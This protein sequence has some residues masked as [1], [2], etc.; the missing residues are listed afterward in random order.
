MNKFFG[1][2]LIWSGCFFADSALAGVAN[3]SAYSPP[4]FGSYIGYVHHDKLKVDQI[5]KLDFLVTRKSSSQ[6]SLNAILTLQFGTFDS[7]EYLSYHFDHVG[8][9]ILTGVL[10]FEQPDQNVILIV[11][12]FGNGEIKGQLSSIFNGHVGS[13]V[14]RQV[15]LSAPANP[16]MPP[17]GGLYRGTCDDLK[18]PVTMELNAIRHTDDT[19]QMGNP[20]GPYRVV[21]TLAES[22]PSV[23]LDF[24][25]IDSQKTCVISDLNVGS[26]N[27]FTGDLV[28]VG[29]HRS[30]QCHMLRDGSIDCNA[31]RF[32]REPSGPAV[33]GLSPYR[34]KPFFRSTPTA[35]S[36]GDSSESIE[37]EYLGYLHHERLDKFQRARITI[38]TYR[39]LLPDGTSELKMAS[40]ANLYFGDF[41]SPNLISYRFETIPFPSPIFATQFVLIRPSTDVDAALSVTYM[42]DGVIRGEWFSILFG[43][44]GTF[45]LRKKGLPEIPVD[46]PVFED[47]SGLYSAPEWQVSLSVSLGRTPINSN[48]PFDPLKIGGYLRNPVLTGKMPLTLSSYDFY[49]GRMS[50]AYGQ[51]GT[52]LILPGVDNEMNIRRISNI[53]GSPLQEYSFERF[54]RKEAP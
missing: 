29:D 21:G 18:Y 41:H 50:V 42:K 6:I 32:Q 31:C 51:R 44:V 40:S 38:R 4:V 30:L 5:A 16:L 36:R 9:N 13:I 28:L 11:D 17:L 52:L 25:D 33:L 45:E 24:D 26:Y 14:L 47:F 19:S 39:T 48:N 23:C 43:R 1:C 27:Y 54:M 22:D 10:T 46:K 8:Y 2:L 37:G 12:R 7:G 20:F 53:Y 49:T 34:A 15:P 3:P 35:M